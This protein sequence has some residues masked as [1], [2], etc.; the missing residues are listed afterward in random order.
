MTGKSIESPDRRRLVQTLVAAPLAWPFAPP[1]A[2]KVTTGRRRVVVVGAGAFGGW[3]ALALARSG[4]DVTLVEAHAAGH[5]RSSSGGETRVIRHMYTDPLYVR[6]AARSLALWREAG[7]NW[8]RPLF[9]QTGVLFMARA[10]GAGFF[11]A[12][13]A[14]M[15]EEGIGYRR[16]DPDAI[17]QRWPQIRLDGIEQGAFEAGTGYLLARR[18]C[19]A[20][21]HAFERAGGTFRIADARPGPIRGGR[22]ASLALADGTSLAADDFVFA[23]GPWLAGLFPEL[24]GHAL[25]VSRQ[26]VYYFGTPPGD[27]AHGEAGL[28]VWADFGPRLW[29]G[30]PGSERRGFK[31]AD[32]THGGPIDPER[33]DRRASAEGIAAAREYL[34]MRFPALAGAPLV[35]ARV[36]QYTNTADGDFIVDRHPGAA[37]LWLVGGGSGHGFKHG[38]ALGELAAAGVLAGQLLEPAFALSRFE[39]PPPKP[40][41]AGGGGPTAA[42]SPAGGGGPGWGQ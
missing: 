35:D 7:R 17:A 12:A 31:I 16:L 14:A 29:Y 25:K 36:C 4:A 20:V 9:H 41:P 30:I 6:M 39:T 18:A 3:T 13:Y 37:N 27:R 23:C 22:L 21:V 8:G 26:E 28:P 15:D 38:P 11:D 33:A 1:G 24:L 32:D 34:A 19:A 42:P 40:S 5:P 10:E 2:A